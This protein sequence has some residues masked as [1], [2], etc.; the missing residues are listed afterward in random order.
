[1]WQGAADRVAIFLGVDV[2]VANMG[3]VEKIVKVGGVLADI[4]GVT[5][6][7]SRRIPWQS[8]R[9]RKWLAAEACPTHRAAA[10]L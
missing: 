7:G 8:D 3:I 6:C 9:E 2:K 5:E 1:M 4:S 10:R